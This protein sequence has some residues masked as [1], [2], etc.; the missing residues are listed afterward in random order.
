M[1]QPILHCRFKITYIRDG[2]EFVLPL[3]LE[4]NWPD[5]L[6]LDLMTM[7]MWYKALDEAYE[8]IAECGGSILKIET[9]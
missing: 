4:M 3:P 2:Q 1:P 6:D 8:R 5:Y 7:N 9:D